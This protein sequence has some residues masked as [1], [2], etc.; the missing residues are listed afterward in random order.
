MSKILNAYFSYSGVTE[1]AAKIAGE[2]TNADMF[3]IKIVNKYP[4][5]YEE[6][7]ALAKK[8][9]KENARPAITAKVDN[10][11][12]Y[13]V[14]ILSYPNW[15]GTLPMPVFT[16]LESYDLSGKTILPICTNGGGGL[17]RSIDDIKKMC[18][19]SKVHNGL[20]ILDKNINGARITI[21]QW[22][23]VVGV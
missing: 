6:V 4:E 15:C 1:K 5:K 3:E 12:D 14:I 21:E 7:V 19:N 17:S 11:N 10:M 23:T 22:L 2:K 9:L 18:P 16:F 8:E 13:D 20:A